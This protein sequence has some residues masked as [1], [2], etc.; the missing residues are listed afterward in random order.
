MHLP[1]VFIGNYL[2]FTYKYQQCKYLYTKAKLQQE[3]IFFHIH[4][5]ARDISLLKKLEIKETKTT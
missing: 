2:H 1:S 3:G 5:F 4:L